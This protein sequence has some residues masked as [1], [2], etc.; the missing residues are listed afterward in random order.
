MCVILPEEAIMNRSLNPQ[1]PRR[2]DNHADIAW[3]RRVCTLPA[4]HSSRQLRHIL[5]VGLSQ[6]DKRRG[7]S[8]PHSPGQVAPAAFNWLNFWLLLFS[9]GSRPCSHICDSWQPPLLRIFGNASR[10]SRSYWRRSVRI[11]YRHVNEHEDGLA[12]ND[13]IT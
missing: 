2:C 1:D 9:F 10:R 4:Q 6:R 12:G 7:F 5:R 11:V 8:F 13:F 3:S